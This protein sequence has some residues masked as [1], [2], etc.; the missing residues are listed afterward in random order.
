MSIMGNL[1][2]NRNLVKAVQRNHTE[3][4]AKGRAD[5]NSGK[6]GVGMCINHIFLFSVFLMLWHLGTHWASQFLE[7]ANNSPR[8]APFICKLTNQEP[9]I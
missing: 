6:G 8:S 2:L 3:L 1:T 7:I 5:V 9:I 4:M